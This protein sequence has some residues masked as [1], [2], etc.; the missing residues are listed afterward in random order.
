MYAARLLTQTQSQYLIAIDRWA[1]RGG[2]VIKQAEGE[3]EGGRE[4]E[5]QI[6]CVLRENKQRN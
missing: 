5:L 6:D 3:G 4:R 1:E 2:Q